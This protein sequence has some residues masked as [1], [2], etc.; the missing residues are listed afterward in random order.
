VEGRVV[1]VSKKGETFA[2]GIA[3]TKIA[4]KFQQKIARMAEDDVDCNTR[5]S[6]G[7]PEACVPTCSF[8]SLCNKTQKAP[9]W[10][11]KA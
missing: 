4:K 11:P 1:R 2:V 9:H 8:H 5:V 7:L 10:P 3:F 6:L